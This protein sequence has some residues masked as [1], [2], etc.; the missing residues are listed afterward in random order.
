MTEFET[1]SHPSRRRLRGMTAA[2]SALALVGVIG[3]WYERAP[4]V[5]AA[6]ADA[7]AIVTTPRPGV[8]ADSYAD[9]LS[10]VAP[11]VVTIRSQQM[12]QQTQLPFD[13]DQLRRFFGERGMRPPAQRA[14]GLG[15]GVVITP[16]GYVLTNEHVVSGAQKVAVELSDGRSFEAKIVGVDKPSDLAVV[17]IP[18]SGLH[19]LPLGDS[20]SARVGDVVF[21]VGNPL[22]IGQSVTMGIVSAKGRVSGG[23][24]EGA[25][26][27]FIQTDAPINQGNSGGAL[28]NTRG[29]LVGIN[30][31]ILSPVGYNIGIGFAIPVNMA[32]TVMDQLVKTGSVKR[33]MLGVTVQSISQEMAKSL[34]LS[35]TSGA[36]VSDVQAESPA[37]KAGLEEGDVILA[38]D[39]KPVDSSNSLRNHIAPL[40]P[41][42]TVKLTVA[43]NGAER[44]V[45]VKL[46]EL[47]TDR[48]E[49][50]SR[51]SAG[52]SGGYGLA[53]QPLTPESPGG[54]A[55]RDRPVSW[56]P[57]SIL[58]V[59]RQR[60]ACRKGTSSRRPTARR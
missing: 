17:K 46:A 22:G 52:P 1:T 34:G 37:A 24:G 4:R 55:W 29:E 15:S 16:D 30:S 49:G 39:G 13:E 43:R 5:E 2:V 50:P 45:A 44:Q 18:A 8:S 21:A 11:A 51:D 7:A 38:L 33:G 31:Q 28:V 9:L 14:M 60:P 56:W 27:D 40:G 35:E 36:I 42:A 26:E 57:K 59:R 58:M 41:D 6:S 54:S 20:D 3:A 19:T 32:R 23:G 10:H 25:F 48:A 53:V 12:V 47:P